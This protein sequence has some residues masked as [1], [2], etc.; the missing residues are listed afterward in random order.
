LLGSQLPGDEGGEGGEAKRL[1]ARNRDGRDS[2][3][4][5][6]RLRYLEIFIDFPSEFRMW[7]TGHNSLLLFLV[8]KSL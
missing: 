6:D 7:R 8:L 1:E 3:G 5:G 2:A 4:C